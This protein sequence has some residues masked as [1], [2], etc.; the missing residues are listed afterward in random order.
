MDETRLY[1]LAGWA[2]GKLKPARAVRLKESIQVTGRLDYPHKDI[3]M[4][5]DSAMQIA[6]LGACRKEPETVRWIEANMRPGDVFFDVGAN[7]GAYSFVADTVAGGRCAVYAFEPSY[8]TFAAL[9]ANV[10]LNRCS[11]RIRTLQIALSN[12]TKLETFNYSST[13]AGA[14]M[15]GLGRAINEDGDAFEPAYQQAVLAFRMDD[16]R[17][18]FGIPVPNHIKVDVDGAELLVVDGA[19]HTLAERA[20]RSMLIEID[21]R[22]ETHVDIVRAI[23]ARGLSLVSKN[24]RNGPGLF[25]Y[26][27]ERRSQ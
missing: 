20:L 21:H 8:S 10:Q 12:E 6:R 5:L 23:E 2:I 17:A 1:K 4:A 18:Q 15:H 7:V 25:N 9:V 19:Q 11:D 3:L 24:P 13:T 26:V 14:A 22:K 27:F 16:L